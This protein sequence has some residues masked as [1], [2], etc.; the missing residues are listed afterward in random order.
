MNRP[1]RESIT[2]P[3]LLIAGA[4]G[5]VGGHVRREAERRKVD[6][7]LMSHRRPVS[8]SVSGP[9]T[10]PAD[11]SDPATLRGVCEGVDILIHCASRIGGTAEANEAVNARGT[12]ALVTEA[13]RAGVSRIVY[14]STTSVYGRGTFRGSRPEELTRNP[15]SFTSHTRARA[16]DA[17]LAAGG[18][19]LRPHL[20]YGEGDMWVG[21]GVGRLL[22]TLPGT[23]AGWPSRMSLIAVRELAGLLVATALAPASALTASVYH[24]AH[25]V[26][27]TAEALL[28]ALAGC[29]GTPWAERELTVEQARAVLAENDQDLSALDMLTTDHVFDSTPLWADVRSD[30]GAGFDHDFRHTAHWYRRTLQST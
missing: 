13:R 25:P 9:R 12:A 26:P 27:V 16:E 29:I 23:V 8:P 21:P 20:V 22:R 19:V 3:T 5:F 17:V 15:G 18:V 1:P 28:R 24:A 7:R 2:A 11:L 4:S 10:V 14:L 6:L 30:P